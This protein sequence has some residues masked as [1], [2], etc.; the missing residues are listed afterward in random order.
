MKRVSFLLILLIQVFPCFAQHDMVSHDGADTLQAF[1]NPYILKQAFVR[2]GLDMTLQNPYGFPFSETIP[3]GTSFGVDAAIGTWLTPEIG[4][5]TKVNWENGL[6]IFENKKL[7]WLG[8]FN[9]PGKNMES[10]GYL[11]LVGDIMFDIHHLISGYKPNRIWNTQLFLRAGGVIN[12]G[13]DKGSP[14]IGLGW[15][16]TFKVSD[17]LKIYSEIAYNGVSSGFTM[18]SRTATGVGS[19][20][21]M[22]FDANLGVQYDL[23]NS[24]S[25]SS[26]SPYHSQFNDR[27]I[28]TN[29]FVQT[30]VDMCLYNLC[31]TDFSDAFTKGRTWGVDA[32]LGR[33]FSP[34][35]GIRGKLNWENGIIENKKLEWLPYD[36]EDASCYDGGGCFLM[37]FDLLLSAK[38]LLLG[39][40]PHSK[41]DMYG[42]CRMGLTS[43]R[44]I[45]SLSPMVG[46][47]IGFTLRINDHLSIYADSGYQGTTSEYFGDISWSGAT[48]NAFNGIW[49]FNIG[50]Q[51]NLGSMW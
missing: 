26:S 3:K 23:F 17:K 18:D 42:F 51:I 44:S 32:A 1:R 4:L 33:W 11:S 25:S 40:V 15:S 7:E 35:I 50:L 36:P 9:E 28:W 46:A 47:G 14:L 43:N 13:L 6:K 31:E 39:Y 21:N 34:E 37:S 38:H 20:S 48:G 41:W 22:Y 19:G 49:D 29:W 2:A 24:Q 8:P 16:N 12:F 5:K 10:G 30:G 27:S 45:G